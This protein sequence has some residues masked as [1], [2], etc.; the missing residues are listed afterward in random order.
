M[1]R[2]DNKHTERNYKS[3]FFA[4]LD[5]INIFNNIQNQALF[6]DPVTT[7]GRYLVFCFLNCL[8]LFNRQI[9]IEEKPNRVSF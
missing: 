2:W 8:V 5:I 7:G 6:C 4:I 9:D 1:K 3:S